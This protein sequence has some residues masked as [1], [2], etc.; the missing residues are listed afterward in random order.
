MGLVVDKAEFLMALDAGRVEWRKHLLI[1]LAER[2]VARQAILDVLRRADLLEEY[3]GRYSF[4]SA[5]FFGLDGE[6]PLHVVAP[7]D[8]SSSFV[9]IVTVYE[10]DLEHFEPDF[11]TRRR[12]T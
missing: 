2:G 4:P 11:R 6:R 1:R 8:K 5:L 9:Y 10:P 12:D 7:Y 3:A